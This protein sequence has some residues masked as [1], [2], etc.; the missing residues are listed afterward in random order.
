MK[1]EIPKTNKTVLELSCSWKRE[2]SA[3]QVGVLHLV[4]VLYH[5]NYVE[6]PFPSLKKRP[7]A[8]HY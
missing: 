1:R 8:T 3:K 7:L 4:S 6:K 2:T 5:R